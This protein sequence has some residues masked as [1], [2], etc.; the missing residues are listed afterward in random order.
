M[1]L[2]CNAITFEYADVGKFISH[3][4]NISFSNSIFYSLLLSLSISGL[5]SLSPLTIQALS[6][7]KHILFRST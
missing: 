1:D 7:E 2:F 6:L 5:L 3:S 4:S